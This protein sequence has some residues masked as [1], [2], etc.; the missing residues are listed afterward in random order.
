MSEKP[1]EHES[2]TGG[3][4]DE[5][6]R[7]TWLEGQG[8]GDRSMSPPPGGEPGGDTGDEPGE[9]PHVERGSPHPN[10]PQ[11]YDEPGR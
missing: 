6:S 5:A 10:E 9:P 11:P 1:S 4:S 3:P 7:P 8:E 2:E